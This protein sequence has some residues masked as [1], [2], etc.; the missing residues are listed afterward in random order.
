MLTSLLYFSFAPLNLTYI[1]DTPHVTFSTN[2]TTFATVV[3]TKGKNSILISKV[4]TDW[5]GL[6]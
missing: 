6:L 5:L 4:I 2:Q 3:V 1:I